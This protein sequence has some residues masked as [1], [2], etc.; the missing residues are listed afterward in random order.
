MMREIISLLF[1]AF[2]TCFGIAQQVVP[3]DGGV[4]TRTSVLF[5]VPEVIGAKTYAYHIESS[6][7]NAID[8]TDENHVTRVDNLSFGE[9]YTWSATALDSS[10]KTVHTYHQE[11]S[12]GNSSYVDPS[13]TRF[14]ILGSSTDAKLDGLVF[15]DYCRVAITPDGTPVWF[16]P[17]KESIEYKR[18]RDVKL[19]PRG[20]VTYLDMLKCEELSLDGEVIWSN[21]KT[22]EFSGDSTDYY[23]HEFTRLSNGNYM[24]LG[25]QIVPSDLVINGKQINQLPLSVIIEYSPEGEVVWT[26]SSNNYVK[27]EDILQVGQKVG[28]GNTFG[29]M[30]SCY[31]DEDAGVIYAGFRDLSCIVVIEKESGKVIQTYGEK[32]PSDSTTQAIGFFSKQHAPTKL[33]GDRLLIFNNNDRN[34]TSSVQIFSEVTETNPKSEILWE[35]FCDFDTLRPAS[36]PRMGNALPLKDGHILVNTGKS[37][38]IF[39][40]SPDKEVIWQCLPEIWDG[41]LKTWRNQPNY[42]VFNVSSLYPFYHTTSL[43]DESVRISNEGSEDDVYTVLS[44]VKPKR[45]KKAKKI[46]LIVSAGASIDIPLKV[47]AKRKRR[48]KTIFIEVHSKNNPDL[49]VKRSYLMR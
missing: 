45:Q 37:A 11:F 34:K 47:L 41:G 12:I 17:E 26:W 22:G 49:V 9:S 40:V 18:L 5:E 36:S 15:L 32:I 28:V 21:P 44:Y 4:I 7:G 8:L 27:D 20:T 24:V 31:V 48:S 39:E 1:V 38:R 30:N 46:E 35:F 19:T 10:G 42:R 25:K 43:R 29:H 2:S 33:P 13:K 6:K 14:R 16:L 23:H 3:P